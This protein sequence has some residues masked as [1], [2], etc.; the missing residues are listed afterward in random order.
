MHH[1]QHQPH[2][3]SIIRPKLTLSLLTDLVLM[4]GRGT[5]TAAMEGVLAQFKRLTDAR[6]QLLDFFKICSLC[7]L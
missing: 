7:A 4:L 6:P 1:K 2:S 3:M 5:L